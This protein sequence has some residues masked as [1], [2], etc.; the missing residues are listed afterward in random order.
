MTKSFYYGRLDDLLESTHKWK[1][2]R[3]TRVHTYFS[4]SELK[5]IK[6]N[7][8][9]KHNFKESLISVVWIHDTEDYELCTVLYKEGIIFLFFRHLKGNHYVFRFFSERVST[10]E[11]CM[12]F[13][14]EC[15]GVHTLR[16]SKTGNV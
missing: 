6:K 15:N 4:S 9:K 16:R 2:D 13:F 14:C 3:M 5:A 10:E 11:D 8:G 7:G 1:V 12:E